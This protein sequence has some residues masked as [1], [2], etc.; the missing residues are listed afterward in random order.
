MA[1]EVN[2]PINIGLKVTGEGKIRDLERQVSA[3]TDEV[4]DYASKLSNAVSQV[5]D[6]KAALENTRNV[7]GIAALEEEL[8]TFRYTASQAED[9][10]LHF[11][12]AM[13]LGELRRNIDVSDLIDQVRSGALTA[14]QAIASIKANF[15]HLMEDNYY[16]SGGLF[17]SQQVQ[18]FL[19]TLDELSRKV[20]VIH[21]K[22]V[23]FETN[24]IAVSGGGGGG[25]GFGADLS[26]QFKQIAITAEAMSERGN[27]AVSHIVS[28]TT[29][30]KE[31]GNID[32]ANLL[33]VAHT[34]GNIANIGQGSFS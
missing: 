15:Q 23:N 9:E 29:A 8:E 26:E 32:T 30:L 5:N 6:L 34:F 20:D 13:N 2:V 31:F 1:R 21:Q 22:L 18:T 19:A 12:N 27:E 10:V 33:Q 25:G 11:L 17:D 28:M 14:N 24:G 16:R 3:L 4:Q 7:S